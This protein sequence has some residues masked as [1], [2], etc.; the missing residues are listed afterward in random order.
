MCITISFCLFISYH[1][2]RNRILFIVYL[3]LFGKHFESKLHRRSFA[4]CWLENKIR[5]FVACCNPSMSYGWIRLPLSEHLT[6]L[7]IWLYGLIA[8]IYPRA[9]VVVISHKRHRYTST[10]LRCATHQQRTASNHASTPSVAHP[11]PLRLS[12][13]TSATPHVQHY[14]H[15]RSS[16]HFRSHTY[17]SY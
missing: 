8:S 16:L 12:H 4:L 3:S 11:L 13:C 5:F 17:G 2:Y 1:F 7:G 10:V 9:V 6:F 14:C 15:I